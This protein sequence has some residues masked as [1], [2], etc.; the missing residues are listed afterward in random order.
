MVTWQENEKETEDDNGKEYENKKY[1]WEV[2]CNAI[3]KENE[4]EM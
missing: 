2:N 3:G 1:K 4:H